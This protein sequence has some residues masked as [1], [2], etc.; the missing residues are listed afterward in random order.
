MAIALQ[1]A[2]RPIGSTLLILLAFNAVLL[3]FGIW[4][5]ASAL[6]LLA[7]VSSAALITAYALFVCKFD[8]IFYV[9]LLLV[10][11]VCG[12]VGV[13]AYR[14]LRSCNDIEFPVPLDSRCSGCPD[15]NARTFQ[16]DPHV[17]WYLYFVGWAVD[18]FVQL[19]NLIPEG[20]CWLNM[21]VGAAALL[22]GSLYWVGTSLLPRFLS[23][24]FS[25]NATPMYDMRPVEEI[26]A[27]ARP[28]LLLNCGG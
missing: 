26:D 20:I 7:L 10:P 12:Y 5:G 16:F 18:W 14:C 27:S 9:I 25:R 15:L 24:L 13:R 21:V 8:P 4:W 11:A 1:V 17:P 6:Q 23:S 19:V 3:V 22:A 28:P 2:Q